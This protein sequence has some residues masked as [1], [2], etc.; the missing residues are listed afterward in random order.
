MLGSTHFLNICLVTALGLVSMQSYAET[1][2][3]LMASGQ[4]RDPATGLIW[5]RCSMGQTWTGNNCTGDAL[6]FTWAE[7]KSYF[8]LF[9][10]KGFAGQNNWRLPKIEELVTLRRCRVGWYQRAEPYFSREHGWLPIGI[11]TKTLPNG[12][13]APVSCIVDTVYHAPA[14]VNLKTFPNTPSDS[15]WSGSLEVKRKKYN[16]VWFVNFRN[17]LLSNRDPELAFIQSHVRGVR[18]P[19]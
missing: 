18:S 13:N 15:Y 12:Q 19:H 2:A 11:A 8:T 9:N 5:M 14:Q 17:G 16:Y 1:D 4:W 3:E 6:E 10:Q 7:A